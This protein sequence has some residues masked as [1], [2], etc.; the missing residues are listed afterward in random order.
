MEAIMKSTV[1]LLAITLTGC[2]TLER[3]PY[4]TGFAVAIVAGSIAA[5]VHH[6]DQ[7]G[8]PAASSIG[9]P[10]CAAGSCR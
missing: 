8:G 3:H 7:R 2:A 6:D 10:L 1:L 4:A 5:S 9:T